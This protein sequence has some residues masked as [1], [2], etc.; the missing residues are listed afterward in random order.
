M[1][2]MFYSADKFNQNLSSWDVKKVGNAQNF[3]NALKSVMTK[4][5]LSKSNQKYSDDKYIYGS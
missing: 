4:D 3:A 2:G 1:N 5:K